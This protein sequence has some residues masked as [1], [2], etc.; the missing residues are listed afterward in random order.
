MKFKVA[1]ISRPCVFLPRRGRLHIMPKIRF[2]NHTLLGLSLRL[3]LLAQLCP[4]LDPEQKSY[5]WRVSYTCLNEPHSTAL[6]W[7]DSGLQGFPGELRLPRGPA[8]CRSALDG[9]VHGHH[10]EPPL[11]LGEVIGNTCPLNCSSSNKFSSALGIRIWTLS[12]N[13]GIGLRGFKAVFLRK[14]WPCSRAASP[15]ALCYGSRTAL[16]LGA[17]SSWLPHCSHG[18]A[19]SAPCPPGIS[20]AGRSRGSSETLGIFSPESLRSVNL[21]STGNLAPAPNTPRSTG[22]ESTPDLP[23]SRILSPLWHWS[24]GLPVEGPRSVLSELRFHV[25]QRQRHGHVDRAWPCLSENCS[26]RC[27]LSHPTSHQSGLSPNREVTD[28]GGWDM[29]LLGCFYC[30][31]RFKVCLSLYFNSVSTLKSLF[32][33][34]AMTS[35][36]RWQ[37]RTRAL[38]IF[39]PLSTTVYASSPM[40]S[41]QI[42][43]PTI[44]RKNC[45]SYQIAV[46]PPSACSGRIAVGK[47]HHWPWKATSGGWGSR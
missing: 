33:A 25:P 14:V 34:E 3:S 12:D 24:P 42:L 47:M 1:I 8:P 36:L 32:K 43:M 26:W 15:Q 11:R 35:I 28:L 2:P 6:T 29:E 23:S 4:Q 31:L 22:S 13:P 7:H 5:A 40:F 39:L 30:F 9:P 17:R 46:Q 18:E 20:S 16:C 38:W 41:G 27:C 10:P 37:L 44:E 21:N 19:G 45:W